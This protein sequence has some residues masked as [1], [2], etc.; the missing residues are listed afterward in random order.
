GGETG[1]FGV[2]LGG[3]LECPLELGGGGGHRV[4]G[5]LQ[6]G[7]EPQAE[8]ATHLGA[9]ESAR[10]GE[11]GRGVPL[12][13]LV[14]EHGVVDGGVLEVTGHPDLGHRDE[15]EPRVLDPGLEHRRDDLLDAVADA[16]H[17][18]GLGHG[19]CLLSGAAWHA[20]GGVRATP[21]AV[22]YAASRASRRSRWTRPP[23]WRCRT[24]G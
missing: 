1:E 16:P 21:G 17:P 5:E 19:C 9:D 22:S 6:G 20:P 11:R 18:G 14:A 8:L 24:P 10:G 2:A 15:A 7:G 13:A 12:L 4:G 3:L 23:C